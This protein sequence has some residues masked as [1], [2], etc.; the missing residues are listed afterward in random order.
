MHSSFH[1][2][3]SL[4][5]RLLSFLEE[6]LKSEGGRAEEWGGNKAPQSQR[7][8]LSLSDFNLLIRS[9]RTHHALHLNNTSYPLLHPSHP[10]FCLS[11]SISGINSHSKTTEDNRWK[12]GLGLQLFCHI[13]SVLFIKI[14]LWRSLD[15][16]EMFF[17][18]I[19]LRRNL[20][21]NCKHVE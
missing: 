6:Y 13:V 16:L 2:F 20:L 19:L 11:S 17:I 1:L 4:D 21:V 15:R 7:D 14:R 9:S 5:Y 8:S 18:P 12:L 3:A 10:Q